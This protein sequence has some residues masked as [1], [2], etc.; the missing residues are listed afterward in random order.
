ML[1]KIIVL[2]LLISNIKIFAQSNFTFS[3]NINITVT[4]GLSINKIGGDL[5]F[6]EIVYDGSKMTLSRSPDL[7]VEFEVTGD[8]RRLV[9]VS[10][11]RRINLDN[12]DWVNT[13]G[14]T[15]GTIRFTANMRNT[16]GS[17]SYSSSSMIRNGRSYRLSNDYPNG[18]LYLWLG[19]SLNI[20]KNQSFGIY[21]GTYT[22]TVAY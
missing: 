5:D 19:G 10:F 13:Y 21:N 12:N 11:P 15:N 17:L 20:N 6:G 2:Y 1:K 18:K 8:R 9:T 16:G 14:G 7:G 22:I 4:T 3:T